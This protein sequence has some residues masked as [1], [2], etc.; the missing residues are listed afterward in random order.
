M[1]NTYSPIARVVASNS[2]SNFV[3]FTNIPQIYTDLLIKTSAKSTKSGFVV[4]NFSLHFNGNSSTYP[5][6]SV[7]F[8]GSSVYNDSGTTVYGAFLGT[9]AGAS[10]THWGIS[11]IYILNYTSSS[12]PKTTSIEN[13]AGTYVSLTAFSRNE[14]NPITSIRIYAGGGNIEQHSSFTLYGILKS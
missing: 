5:F 13:G 1:A 8:N 7:G 3:D 14:T 4:D 10:A 12:L 11:N 2:S 6:K 9:A